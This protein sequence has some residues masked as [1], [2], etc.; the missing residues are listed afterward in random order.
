[1][2]YTRYWICSMPLYYGDEEFRA[3]CDS[4][5]RRTRLFFMHLAALGV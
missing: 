2:Q 4:L 5:W 1:M 3:A